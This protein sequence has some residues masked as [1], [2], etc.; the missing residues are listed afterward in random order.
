MVATGLPGPVEIIG[1]NGDESII[2]D[3]SAHTWSF[4][5]GLDGLEK[6]FY[7][8]PDSTSLWQSQ[9][10]PVN[11]MMTW[12]KVYYS[13]TMSPASFFQIFL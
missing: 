10:L 7:N 2:K 5:V 3:L 8:S 11:R 12:Y 9:N 13:I 6:K 4:K 1:R